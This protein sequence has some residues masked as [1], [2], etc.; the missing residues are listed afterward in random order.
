MSEDFNMDVQEDSDSTKRS[1]HN[2]LERRRRDHIKDSFNSLRDSVPTLNGE[3]ASRAQI[4]NKATEYINQM[5][6]KNTAFKNDIDNLNKENQE[7][8]M[9]ISILEAARKNNLIAKQQKEK[10]IQSEHQ[11]GTYNVPANY[12]VPATPQQQQNGFVPAKNGQENKT[13]PHSSS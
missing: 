5:T 6:K 8:E 11:A 13:P 1:H 4:L 2:A 3:K 9:K 7:L 12:N 10:Q